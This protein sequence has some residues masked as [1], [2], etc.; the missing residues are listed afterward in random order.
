MLDA[1]FN[2][3]VKDGDF[4]V[5]EST[6]QHQHLLLITQ[7]GEIRQSPLTGVGLADF[8]ESEDPG[9]L[10]QTIQKQFELDGMS[11]RRLVIGDIIEVEAS[12]D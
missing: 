9:I 4:V 7:P 8:L 6:Q 2:W 10:K 12:Y 3:Q 11:I 1:D 5:G